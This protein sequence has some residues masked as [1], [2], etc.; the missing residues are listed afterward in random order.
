MKGTII[1]RGSASWRLEVYLG[2][3]SQGRRL[4]KIE[5]VRGKKSDAQRRMR[6]ILGNLDKG[7]PL[8]PKRYKLSEWL[9]LWM[10]EVI[11]P[12]RRQ[13]TVDRYEGVIRLHIVP[14]LGNF[15]LAKVT[16]LQIQQ[17]ESQ[18]LQEGMSSRGVEMIHVVLS[19]ALRHAHKM[20]LISRNPVSLVSPP[21]VEKKQVPM[22]DIS[23]VLRVLDLARSIDHYL[24]PCI[25][26]VA[27][28]GMR[29]G[30]ALG[31][32]WENVDLDNQL[33]HVV[34]SLVITSLGPLR[35]PPK[36]NSGERIIDLDS[37]TVAVLRSH[38]ENQ[39]QRAASVGEPLSEFVFTKKFGVGR[40]HPNTLSDA[41][42]RLSAQAGH[43]ELTLRSLRHFHASVTLQA[44]QNVVVISKR[45]GH[46]KVSITSDIYAHSLP[47]W[48]RA[49]AQAFAETLKK[50][51]DT[52]AAVGGQNG[53]LMVD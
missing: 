2:R 1:Q 27:Y 52:E 8:S 7:V 29:R 28:T 26:L 6:E 19:G 50:F 30:E 5:T 10:N 16:P 18:L 31:L 35:Q 21:S 14:R 33:I 38:R 37:D 32:K 23:A 41:V 15:D 44:G 4:R 9:S 17:L 51:A 34:D 40:C 3:D 24:W 45:L 36:T 12:N 13:K 53:G 20:D 47:G 22:P 39:S 46:S 25:H 11:V 49:A 42:A 48:Q 43:P